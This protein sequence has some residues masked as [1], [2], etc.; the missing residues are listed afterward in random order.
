MVYQCF[1]QQL[2]EINTVMIRICN[3]IIE[4]REAQEFAQD[5]TSGSEFCHSMAS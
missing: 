5:H 3:E 1:S 2:Y 4:L